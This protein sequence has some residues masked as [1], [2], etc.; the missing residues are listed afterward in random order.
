MYLPSIFRIIVVSVI[1]R[2]VNISII[3]IVFFVVVVRFAFIQI[4]PFLYSYVTLFPLHPPPSPPPLPPPPPPPPPP[5]PPLL[6]T[7]YPNSNSITLPKLL[8]HQYLPRAS[9]CNHVPFLLISQRHQ[10]NLFCL[11]FFL[12]E[13]LFSSQFF[14]ILRRVN[15]MLYNCAS[16]TLSCHHIVNTVFFTQKTGI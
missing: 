5:S 15:I 8:Y 1:L 13:C 6:S 10:W 12:T 3:T 11:G 2:T 16:L 14:Y 7:A 4:S 9:F